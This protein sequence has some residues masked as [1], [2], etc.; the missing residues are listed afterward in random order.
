MRRPKAR[1]FVWADTKKM[2][3]GGVGARLES[4]AAVVRIAPVWTQIRT[5][6]RMGSMAYFTEALTI[7]S[8]IR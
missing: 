6:T 8:F 3:P 7:F 1:F 4:A 5:K 2:F